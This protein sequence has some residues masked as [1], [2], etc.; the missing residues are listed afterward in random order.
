MSDTA[1]ID[2][3]IEPLDPS[4]WQEYQEAA[5]ETQSKLPPDGAYKVRFPDELPE[6]SFE[7]RKDKQTG[8][9]YLE[10]LLDNGQRGDAG[11]GLVITDG[12]Y[13]GTAVRF[14][15]V[16]TRLIQEF[17]RD[18]AAWKPTGK[19]LNAS[20]AADVLQNFATGDRPSTTEEWKAAFRRLCGQETPSAVYFTWA[21]YDKKAQGKAK[22]LKSKDFPSVNGV[23]RSYVERTDPATGE[24][25]RVFANLRLGRRG[26]APKAQQ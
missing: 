14:I 6:A 9:P 21:G 5:V 4:F 15:R 13:A 10:I 8:K 17:K 3:D 23:R 2:N 1:V 26:F 11:Q 25:Y 19:V 7:V 12:V 16:D 22:Y 18:G 20:D 24:I